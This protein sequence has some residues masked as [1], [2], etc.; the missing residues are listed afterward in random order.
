MLTAS[1]KGYIDTPENV[2][3]TEES[4]FV[5]VPGSSTQSV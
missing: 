5:V 2:W 3:S 4:Y 1:A